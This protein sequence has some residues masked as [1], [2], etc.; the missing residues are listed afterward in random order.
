MVHFLVSG[1][2][3]FYIALGTLVIMNRNQILISPLMPVPALTDY[4]ECWPL[5]SGIITFDQNWHHLYLKAA[6]GKDLFND[7]QIVVFGSIEDEICR[8]MFKY[9]SEKVE[10]KFPSTT[11]GYSVVRIFLIIWLAL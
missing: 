6:R 11:V 9:W 7:T 3:N 4:D 5:H 2:I 1:Q 10:A 8:K